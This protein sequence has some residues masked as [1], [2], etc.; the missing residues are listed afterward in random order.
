MVTARK[1]VSFTENKNNIIKLHDSKLEKYLSI[2]FNASISEILGILLIVTGS[3][4]KIDA[5]ISAT[6]LFLAPL[7]FIVPFNSLLPSIII[8]FIIPHHFAQNHL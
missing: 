2:S 1:V 7:I 8:L 5:G 4:H 3:S 6:A